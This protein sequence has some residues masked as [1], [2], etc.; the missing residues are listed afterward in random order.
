MPRKP[1]SAKMKSVGAQLRGCRESVGLLLREAAVLV[2]WDK[3]K[4]SRVENGERTINPEEAAHLLGVYR[5][6]AQVR[7]EILRVVRTLDEPGWWG[8]GQQDLEGLPK[9][10]SVLADYESEASRLSNWEP[11]MVPGLLQTMEYARAF[12]LGTGADPAGTDLR[13]AA[14]FRRQQ[15]LNSGVKYVAFLGESALHTPVGDSALMARQLA[16][17]KQTATRP[18]VLV[19]VVPTQVGPH[20]GQR[21]PFTVLEFPDAQ[22]VVMAELLR[23]SVFIDEARQ[24]APYLETLMHLVSVALSETDSARLISRLAHM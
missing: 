16:W 13:L 4:L 8:Q 7:E 22:P 1:L 2:E 12:L 9:E 15:I 19:R 14:R 18:N 5:I 21:G 17:I 20:G 23:S 11:L 24:I 6:R 10:T 3:S